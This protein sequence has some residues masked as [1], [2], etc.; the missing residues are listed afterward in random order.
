MAISQKRAP[1]IDDPQT[2]R[3]ISRIYDDINELI[4][5]V[6]QSNT[7]VEKGGYEGKSGDI[8]LFKKADATY[9]IQGRTDEG[10]VSA[11]MTF[12]EK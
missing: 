11:T 7:T 5:A 1:S 9:E 6:N 12:K 8:R 10:W 3:I 4:N 2:G